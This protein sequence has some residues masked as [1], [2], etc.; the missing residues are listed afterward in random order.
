MTYV[1]S[2]TLALEYL[3][4]LTNITSYNSPMEF[5]SYYNPYPA[6]TYKDEDLYVIPWFLQV[7]FLK[8][9]L[10]WTVFFAINLE[11]DSINTIWFDFFNLVLLTIYFFNFG[12][13][14][15][16]KNIKVSFSKTIS[17]EK[18]LYEYSKLVLEK[19]ARKKRE[20]YENCVEENILMFKTRPE[21]EIKKRDSFRD[22]AS[23]SEESFLHGSLY[24]KQLKEEI[25]VYYFPKKLRYV[26][27]IGSSIPTIVLT[28]LIAILC[29]SLM[30][31]GY[32]IA[33]IYLMLRMSDFFK[34]DVLQYK[35]KRWQ[36]QYIICG[37]LMIFSFFDIAI[38]ILC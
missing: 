7:P 2:L 15:N 28:F 11:H 26:I 6:I 38:Q 14:I 27:F 10:N 16:A 18:K 9:N 31:I 30:S 23:D 33:A 37:P 19:K 12:N 29:S 3:L 35:G 36:H 34:Q 22:G 24:L 13:P 8:E 21:A 1:F 4:M 32:I 25:F 17:L 5:P 20:E